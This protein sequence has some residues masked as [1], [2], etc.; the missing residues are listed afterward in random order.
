MSFVN[1]INALKVR[2]ENHAG[3]NTFCQNTFGKGLNVQKVFKHRTE[4]QL[5]DFPIVMITRPRKDITFAGEV[6]R[7]E[8]SVYL[9]AG[10]HQDDKEK[11]LENSIEFEEYLEQAVLNKTQIQGDI[12][13]AVSINDSA[14]DEGMFHPV[15]F[16][17]MHL[18]VKTR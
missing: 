9:Y 5:D 10:F 14:N 15:Y 4:V 11:A 8:Q 13:M 18:K 1:N 12:P 6:S 7:K 2:L 17:V 16:L 3:L